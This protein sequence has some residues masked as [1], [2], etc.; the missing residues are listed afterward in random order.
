M[1]VEGPDDRVGRFRDLLTQVCPPLS[2]ID[3]YRHKRIEPIGE[4]NFS[5]RPSRRD[6]PASALILPDVAA[7]EECRREI[8]DPGSRRY[9]YP[10]TNCTNCG[11][12][13]SIVESLPYDRA[14]TTMRRFTMCDEC[15]REFEDPRDRRFHAQPNACAKCGPR[16]ELWDAS[17]RSPADHED[18]LSQA[19][20]VIQSG[21][22]LALKGLG[23]FQLIV[24]AEN[25]DAVRCLRQRKH[26]LEK[27]LALMYPSFAAIED[28]CI[29]T[30]AEKEALLSCTAP[31]TLL[32]RKIS[33]ATAVHRVSA[34][35]APDNPYLGVMLPYTP[36]HHLLMADLG[37]PV[38]ATSG[39]LS[40]EPICTDE[41]DALDRLR[42]I[43]DMFLVHDRPIARPVDDSVVRLMADHMVVLRSAR[44]YAPT[45]VDLTNAV[46]DCLAVGTQVKNTVAISKGKRVIISQH[47]GDLASKAAFTAMRRAAES[48]LTT[49]GVTPDL[50]ACDLHPDYRSS[51]FASSF[52]HPPKMVQHHYAHVLSCMAEHRLDSPVLG[53][54]FDGT[55]LGDDGTIWG[56]EFLLIN[57]R[58]FERIAHLRRFRLPGGEAAVREPRRAAVGLLYEGLGV[59]A[60]DMESLAPL[61]SFTPQERCVLHNMLIKGV[62]APY[63]SS[64]GRLF[65]AVSSLLGL[66]QQM[67]FEGQAAMQLEF[68]A[69]QAS[70]VRPYEYTIDLQSAP[71][72]LDWEPMLRQILSDLRESVTPALIAAGFHRTLVAM[73][74]TVVEKVGQRRVVLTGGCFQNRYLTECA[75]QSLQRRGFEVYMHERVP[76]ND[77]G[78]AL[79]QIM[80]ATRR[81][82]GGEE[83]C[84]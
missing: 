36:L 49:Y 34:A 23:G 61:A 45:V 52:D 56:G 7:C 10:F 81:H 27:P 79:G 51:V 59:A 32:R 65:D 38:V 20:R 63:T 60:F 28:D 48:L 5:I 55:G 11:P 78:I 37:M 46:V 83:Q 35:V 44:G 74:S 58:S 82:H 47:I 31:I 4:T 12:R 24:D 30:P 67:S 43:A 70:C 1:E 64:A 53:V 71:Y 13:F 73:I 42:G 62:N 16:L 21:G 57:E 41:H 18:A 19:R 17:G 75:L 39:N 6:G 50:V 25:D 8:F 3:G 84:A 40:E 68:V 77:A 26:R 66:C 9:R 29:V 33:S 54:A 15:R 14:N 69:E 22:I 80:A 72:V 76:P 2:R